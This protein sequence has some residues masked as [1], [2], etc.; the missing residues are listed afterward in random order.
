MRRRDVMLSVLA[1]LGFVLVIVFVLPT[2]FGRSVLEA[3]TE[4]WYVGAVLIAI[5]IVLGWRARRPAPARVLG[6]IGVTLVS[7]AVAYSVLVVLI[8]VL[9]RPML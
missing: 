4:R 2:P 6:M 7:V 3:A 1:G 9:F 5:S 8:F